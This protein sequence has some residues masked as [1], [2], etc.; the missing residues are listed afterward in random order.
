MK[1]LII[2]SAIAGL[3][4]CAYAQGDL[5]PDGSLGPT[6]GSFLLDNEANTSASENAT[7]GGLVWIGNTFATAALL[8]S[9]Q[10]INV[11]VY[12]GSTL[13]VSL[14]GGEASG[15]AVALG[16]NGTFT[17]NSETGYF[18]IAAPGNATPYTITLDLWTGSA[19]TYAAALT[20][21]GTYAATATFAQVLGNVPG[22]PLPSTPA[23]FSS[24]PAMVLLPAVPEP[25][26]IALATLGGLS[27]LGLR[28]RKTA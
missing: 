12:D 28:R 9:G 21:P 25:A 7:S 1:K 17:D 13:V 14:T 6:G 27:L 18:D 10:D 8:Q 24:M 15:D 3:S 16:P 4:I 22:V 5:G 26:T 23:T 20:T 19:T 2:M 11:A